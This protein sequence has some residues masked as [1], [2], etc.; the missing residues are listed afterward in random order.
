[1]SRWFEQH[2]ITTH[3]YDVLRTSLG[4]EHAQDS[5][6]APNIQDRLALEEMGVVDDGGAVGSR[7][8][9]I[10]QHLLVNT[11]TTHSLDDKACKK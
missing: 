2:A 11:W 9:G 8:H 7:A 3:S 1:M 4:S 10:L 5:G 6:T